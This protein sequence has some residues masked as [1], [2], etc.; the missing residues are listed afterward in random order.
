MQ[1]KVNIQKMKRK[2]LVLDMQILVYSEDL[3]FP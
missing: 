1:A 2:I 3:I